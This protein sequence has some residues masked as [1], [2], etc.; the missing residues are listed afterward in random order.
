MRPE[1][2]STNLFLFFLFFVL[3]FWCFILG[4]VNGLSFVYVVTEKISSK[5]TTC[6]WMQLGIKPI[7]ANYRSWHSHAIT[8]SAVAINHHHCFLLIG[9]NAA[10]ETSN[11]GDELITNTYDNQTDPNWCMWHCIRGCNTNVYTWQ[12]NK[13]RLLHR[14]IMRHAKYTKSITTESKIPSN[15]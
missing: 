9:S 4:V 7:A 3:L 6:G 13:C 1:S 10:G 14:M 2:N 5:R 12:Q 8:R 11:G 15:A